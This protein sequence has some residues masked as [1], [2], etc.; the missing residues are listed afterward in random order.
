M[1]KRVVY[2]VP[3]RYMG[4]ELSVRTT[5]KRVQFYLGDELVKTHIRRPG[6][7]RQTDPE[8]LRADK[9]AFFQ[10]TAQWC[11][12][13]AKEIG[14]SVF[15]LVLELLREETLTHLRQA[16]GIIRLCNTY[17]PERFNRACARAFAFGDAGY[18]TVKGILS[19]GLDEQPTPEQTSRNAGALLHGVDAFAVDSDVREG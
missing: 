14:E 17:G 16:R 4:Q 19:C 13:Q 6:E 11:I 5:D 8:D 7:R 10:R 2:S 3:W 12:R 18:K 1:V 9:T 15:R